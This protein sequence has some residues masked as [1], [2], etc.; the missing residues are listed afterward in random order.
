M[1]KIRHIA[2]STQDVDKTAKF[3]IEVFG[4]KEIAK[5]NSP[6]A[7]GYYLTDG[8]INLAILNFRNDAVA[9]VERGKDWSGIH[10]IGFQVESLEA[11]TEKLREAGSAP[12]D[13]IN[14]ALGVGHGR[15][16]GGNVEVKYSG[17]DG[18]TVDVSETG[19]VG[20]PT[21]SPS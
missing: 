10:H 21:F 11:I 1:P 13:D 16:E 20:T 2:L 4:M 3:Y 12:R 15:R 14:D 8:D 5:V 9:G 7:T 6:G 17:P 19:W 18:V